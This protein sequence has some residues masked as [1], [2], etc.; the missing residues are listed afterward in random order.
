MNGH[1][2][3]SG[4]RALVRRL[5]HPI[6]RAVAPAAL[7]LHGKIQELREE[8]RVLREELVELRAELRELQ[9]LQELHGRVDG[10]ERRMD[11]LDE[12]N[13]VLTDGLQES[14][15]LN[16][17]IAELAD[18]VTELVLPLHDREIDAGAL[19]SLRP[20]AG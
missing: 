4:S 6:R 20:D 1:E 2:E 15:R 12:R 16:L 5:M 8:N 3:L 14:R 13:G 17:R 9:E 7:E 11:L 19:R 10:V 18:V